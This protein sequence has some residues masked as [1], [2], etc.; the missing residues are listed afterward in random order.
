MTSTTTPRRARRMFAAVATAGLAAGLVATGTTSASAA[1]AWSDNP[2]LN[3]S[4]GLDVVLVL[5]ASTSIAASG[6][7]AQVKSAATTLLK[8]FED[9]NTR[10]GIVTFA[11]TATQKAG[12]TYATGS[13]VASSGALGA[14]VNGY[15]ASGTGTN[16]DDALVKAKA[17][18][19]AGGTRAHVQQLVILVTDGAPTVY[20]NSSGKVVPGS[21]YPGPSQDSVNAAIDPANQIKAGGAHMLA[22]GV[23]SNF[24]TGSTYLTQYISWLESVTQTDP[25]GSRIANL[26][27]PTDQVDPFSPTN[28]F[29][30]AFNP[31][32]TDVLVNPDITVL[33]DKFAT[34]AAQVCDSSL[35]IKHI[36]NTPTAPYTNGGLVG[37]TS[38]ATVDSAIA[39]TLP[40]AAGSSTGPETA[41]SNPVGNGVYQWSGPTGW[42]RNATITLSNKPNYT[43]TSFSCTK[44][45][46]PYPM[47]GTG[48]YTILVGGGQITCTAS[49]HYAGLPQATFTMSPKAVT[50]AYG[51]TKTAI[52]G[53]LTKPGTSR[54]PAPVVIA[55][56]AVKLQASIDG[57]LTW[58]TAASLKTGKTGLV[59]AT[60][61]P[62]NNTLYRW[63]YKSTSASLLGNVSTTLK[64]TVAARVTMAVNKQNVSKGTTVT[65]TGGVAPSKKYQTVYLQRLV[66]RTWTNVKS[67][68]LTRRSTYAIAWK[69]DSHTD[70]LWRVVKKGDLLNATAASNVIKLNVK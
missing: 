63:S 56:A 21:G 5:D 11:A 12:L 29:Y 52:A 24:N 41:T 40:V 65:F 27:G 37:W 43:L 57:G 66:G 18:L 70:Y 8:S 53:V 67:T 16:W 47:S 9:T 62:A 46:A 17:E 51:A 36:G 20:N 69:T 39:W 19:T 55:G 1:T 4:C 38:S 61:A 28:A 59:A 15:K 58:N 32:T 45:G 33:G 64:F 7:E 22:I 2:A 49:S 48:P 10:V 34:V 13:T 25:P 14:A 68:T 60:V 31:I 42:N 23:G 6:G 3:V 44:A 54:H 35:T 50:K 26:A 30:A